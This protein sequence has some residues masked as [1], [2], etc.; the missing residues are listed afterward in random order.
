MRSGCLN[1][2]IAAEG[3]IRP[4]GS[5]VRRSV[6]FSSQ[7]M[8]QAVLTLHSSSVHPGLSFIL[9]HIVCAARGA[10]YRDAVCESCWSKTNVP[11]PA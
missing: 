8:P 2:F 11:P 1:D 10:S 5:R 4:S 7:K 9:R 3:L 6:D